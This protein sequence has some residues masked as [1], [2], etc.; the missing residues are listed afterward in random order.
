[1]NLLDLFPNLTAFNHEITS[2]KTIKYNCIAWVARST[3]RWW[4]PGIHWP[5]MSS[6]EDIG[7]GDLVL[8]F[9]SLG[10]EALESSDYGKV[11]QFMKRPLRPERQPQASEVG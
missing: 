8:A 11:V 2:E 4:Q 7:I 3:D 5:I 10:Y 6:R 1:M 9:R